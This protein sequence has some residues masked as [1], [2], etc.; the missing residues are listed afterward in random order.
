MTGTRPTLLVLSGL[1]GTGKTTVARE[2]CRRTGAVHLRVDAIETAILRSGV[3]PGAAGYVV[4]HEVARGNLAL[5]TSVVVDAVC[6]VAEARQGWATTAR[7]AG[8]DLVQVGTALADAAEHRRRV[9]RRTADLAGHAVPGW[10]EVVDRPW[11]AWDDE[12][13]G[14]RTL[15]DAT[16]TED[17]VR[18][19]LALLAE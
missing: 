11:D 6:A 18:R 10:Q 1:P 13:D 5:G 7:E 15:V 12:R 4:A 16:V 14:P 8:A 19:V 3:D 2:V 9:E 17:A